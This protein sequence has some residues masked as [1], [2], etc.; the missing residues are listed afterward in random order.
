MASPSLLMAFDSLE[1]FQREVAKLVDD[2]QAFLEGEYELWVGDA[3]ELVLVHPDSGDSFQLDAEVSASQKDGVELKARATPLIRNQL[4]KFAGLRDPVSNIHERMRKLSMGEVGR[5]AHAGE[6]EE[7]VA[8]E[9]MYGKTVWEALLSNPKLTIG[10]V[11]RFARNG[12]M[13]RP[14]LER[15]VANGTWVRVPQIR[16]AL[17]THRR[18]DGMLIQRVLSFTPPAELKLIAKQT[19][20]TAAV[21]AAAHKILG[22]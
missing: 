14:M 19:A 10:E 22:R 3:C 9:R 18:L 12:T 4:R 5:L 8:L 17:L 7:R 13:P 2:S 11:L 20:Y 15:I 1:Q 6:L 21:R 16:R